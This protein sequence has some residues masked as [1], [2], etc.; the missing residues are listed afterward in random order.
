MRKSIGASYRTVTGL[1]R[2]LQVL[3][4]LNRQPDGIGTTTS[5]AAATSLH[6]TTVKRL[7]E[8]LRVL[9][10]LRL[11]PSDESYR[12]QLRV[13]ELSEGFTDDEWVSAVATPVLGELLIKLVWPS[14][15]TTL[16]GDAMIIRETTHRF[17]P[18]SFHRDMVGRRMPMFFTASGRAYF[19]HCPDRER[20]ELLRVIA[21]S[22]DEQQ[23]RFAR[24]DKLVQ[25]LVERTRSDGFGINDGDWAAEPQV[26]ALAVPLYA[27]GKVLGCI[28]VV[29][30]RRAISVA[31]AEARF[32]PAMREAA[33]AVRR[34]AEG[35]RKG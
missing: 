14:D 5:I 27:E 32:L 17:S 1:Q 7:L 29:Y 8:T 2:G 34:G 20:E 10:Y 28:N 24:N 21:A 13:R 30:L 4:A 25:R 31:E 35:T 12:L 6:R 15:L 9:D 11:S 18:L 3:A 23:A 33:E 19:G 26:G 22:P 16:D